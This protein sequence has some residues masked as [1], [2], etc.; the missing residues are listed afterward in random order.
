MQNIFI[1]FI[2][3]YLRFS[4]RL[5]NHVILCWFQLH[6]FYNSLIFRNK[7]LKM[8]KAV[9]LL[10]CLHHY[11]RSDLASRIE[12]F[13]VPGAILFSENIHQ[14]ITNQPHLPSRLLGKFHFENVNKPSNIFALA[15]DRL[16]VPK[17][18]ETKGKGLLI[19]PG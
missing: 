15:I 17:P 8:P 5:E 18:E 10:I 9:Y 2:Q 19:E 7:T 1:S 6:Q 13:S 12:S 4:K 3:S 16:A 14:Q 11:L